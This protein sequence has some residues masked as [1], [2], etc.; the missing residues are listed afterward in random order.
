MHTCSRW[1]E[2]A[3]P[4][5]R[6]YATSPLRATLFTPHATR[7]THRRVRC[8]ANRAAA[9]LLLL[10]CCAAVLSP[11]QVINEGWTKWLATYLKDLEPAE[12]SA[13]ISAMSIIHENPWNKVGPLLTFSCILTPWEASWRGGWAGLG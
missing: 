9:R 12:R 3:A 7:T 1:Y 2:S 5:G 10:L 13:K 6:C 8:A 4:C 11:P